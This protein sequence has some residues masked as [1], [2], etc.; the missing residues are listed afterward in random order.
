[1]S[2]RRSA[3]SYGPEIS[4]PVELKVMETESKHFPTGSFRVLLKEII[5]FPPFM[6]GNIGR[7]YWRNHTIY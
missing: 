5:F 7:A 6:P 3:S 4:R 1:M 2:P